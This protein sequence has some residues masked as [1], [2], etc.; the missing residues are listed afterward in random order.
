MEAKAQE[1]KVFI[2]LEYRQWLQIKEKK[3]RNCQKKGDLCGFRLLVGM[4][5]QNRYSR[6]I[7][8]VADI[9]SQGKQ[10]KVGTDLTLIGVPTLNLGH[11][12]RV[13]RKNLEQASQRGQRA[14]EKERKRKEQLDRERALA[15]EIAA[16]KLKLNK[17]GEQVSSICFTNEVEQ[18]VDSSTQTEEFDYLVNTGPLPL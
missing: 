6:T 4:I 15:E 11:E 2:F 10:R 16:K 8:F 1:I 7:E 17:A 9:S 3:P 12:K 14:N 18:S 13:E 5:Y